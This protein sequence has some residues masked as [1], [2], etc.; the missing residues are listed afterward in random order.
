MAIAEKLKLEKQALV[1]AQC[2]RPTLSD[3]SRSLS[4][5]RAERRRK[6]K[7]HKRRRPGGL[8]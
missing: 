6:A 3:R 8:K 7:L 5:N 2:R 1:R 4:G